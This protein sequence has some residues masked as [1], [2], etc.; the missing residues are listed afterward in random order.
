M[1]GVLEEIMCSSICTGFSRMRSAD[2]AP[3]AVPLVCDAEELAQPTAKTKREAARTV[4][5]A[6][7]PD[8]TA[9]PPA[10]RELRSKK[11]AFGVLH[12]EALPDLQLARTTTGEVVEPLQ[13]LDRG[14]EA[15]RDGPEGVAR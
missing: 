7:H 6:V 9:R 8:A 4:F 13:A 14:G 10:R 3:A 5:M 12:R 15:R 2:L 11:S 1:P